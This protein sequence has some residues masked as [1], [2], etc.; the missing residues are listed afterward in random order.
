L[1]ESTEPYL[2]DMTHSRLRPCTQPDP[3]TQ[4]QLLVEKWGPIIDLF[5]THR[6]AEVTT[7]N[8]QVPHDFVDNLA[9]IAAQ[10]AVP[11]DLYVFFGILHLITQLPSSIQFEVA[12]EH[13]LSRPEMETARGRSLFQKYSR[14]IPRINLGSRAAERKGSFK[15]ELSSCAG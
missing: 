3:L 11:A 4:N 10:H 7:I 13:L 6:T 1:I 9:R 14:A 12:T 15:S 8:T 5:Q 2:V